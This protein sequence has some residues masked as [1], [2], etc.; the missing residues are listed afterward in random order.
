M[1]AK[2]KLNRFAAGKALP[3]SNSTNIKSLRVELPWEPHYY[4]HER[5]VDD[6][7]DLI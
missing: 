6:I 1:V 2:S 3:C 4:C 7:V 5:S